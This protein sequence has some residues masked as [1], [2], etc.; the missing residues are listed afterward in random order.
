ME[1]TIKSLKDRITSIMYDDFDKAGFILKKN[2]LVFEKKNSQCE[3]QCLFQ[4]YDYKP[5]RIEYHFVFSFLIKTLEDDLKDFFKYSGIQY[6]KGG[7]MHFSEGDFHPKVCDQ[8]RKF[9]YAFTHSITDLEIDDPI[10]RESRDVIVEE[11][12]PRVEFFSSLEEFQKFILFDYS[13]AI[14]YSIWLYA[15][16]AIRRYD[17]AELIAITDYIAKELQ[18]DALPSTHSTRKMMESFK[19]YCDEK[20]AIYN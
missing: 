1:L 19:K 17:S 20:P 3:M 18:V 6:K 11:F 5:N 10:I 8:P 14:Q 2:R 7:G 4:F 15:L 13:I 9:R 12:L 16:L